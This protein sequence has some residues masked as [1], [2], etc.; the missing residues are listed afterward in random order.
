MPPKKKIT[1]ILLVLSIVGVLGWTLTGS[2]NASTAVNPIVTKH[3]KIGKTDCQECHSA[4]VKHKITHPVAEDCAGCHEYKETI[5]SAEVKLVNPVPGLCFTCHSDKQEDFEKKKF[6][7]AAAESDCTVCH[8]PHSADEPTLLKDKANQL[9][10]MC[11]SDQQDEIEHK[12]FA[13]APIKDVG[14]STCHDP[15]TANFSP[16]LKVKV[17][18]LCLTCHGLPVGDKPSQPVLTVI[19]HRPMPDKYSDKAKKIFLDRNGLGHPYFN[20]PVG[21]VPDPSQ[22]GQMMTCL[23]CHNPHAGKVVQ[24]YKADVGKQALCDKCHK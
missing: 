20:H 7:H 6:K 21:G 22:P 15:H 14:C 11:H 12:A 18:E 16:L 24:M 4:V 3:K 2:S 5:D 8:S 9:C 1:V 13:H 17:N 10:F 19:L 23:S